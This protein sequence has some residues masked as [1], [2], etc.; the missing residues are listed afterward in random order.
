MLLVIL[1]TSS[2]QSMVLESCFRTNVDLCRIGM[3]KIAADAP[4]QVQSDKCGHS[5][6]MVQKITEI[7]VGSLRK[8][9]TNAN[10]DDSERI[11]EWVKVGLGRTRA[12]LC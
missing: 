4:P 5:F 11:Y 6:R 7:R 1:V 3:R 12:E 10:L 8:L 9:F 2:G